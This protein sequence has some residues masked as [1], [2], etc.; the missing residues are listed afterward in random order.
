MEA[1]PRDVRSR[2]WIGRLIRLGL[3]AFAVVLAATWI[4]HR[5]PHDTVVVGRGGRRGNIGGV[6]GVQGAVSDA[7]LGPG[8]MRI[9]N[10]DSTV[11]LILKGNQ[12]LAGLSPMTVAKVKAEMERS[13]AKDTSGLGGFIAST[14]KQTV[15]ST[16]GTHVSYPL[17]DIREIRFEDGQLIAE[18]YNGRETR[19]FGDT[20][21]NGREQGKTFDERDAERFIEAVRARKG[22]L[23]QP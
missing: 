3:I 8:D 21:V 16:I 5:V 13:S 7:S 19:L 17:S 15:A 6:S 2:R 10:R 12:I 14:V 11:D 9:Y 1:P 22:Q 23:G 4:A 20:K 18:R